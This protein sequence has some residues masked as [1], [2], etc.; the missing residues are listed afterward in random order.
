MTKRRNTLFII[1]FGGAVIVSISLI[2]MYFFSL[3][4]VNREMTFGEAVGVVDIT[5]EIYYDQ[6]KIQE[7]EKYR[8]NDHIKAV[9]IH[10]NS[11]GGGVAASQELY[12]AVIQLRSHKPVVACLGA[13]A[14]S[15]GYYVACAADSIVALE[16]TV[17]GSIGVIA[18]F[19]RT[20]DLYQKIGLGVTVLKSGKYKD[21]GSP[22]R[23]MTQ[24]EKQYIGKL[25]DRVYGQFISAVSN[26]RGIPYEEVEKLAEGRIYSGAEAI[27]VGL[28]DRLGTFED[29]ILL[30][31]RLG[32]ISGKPRI[33]HRKP[34][35][36]I[37]DKLLGKHIGRLPV[38]GQ[39]QRFTLKYIVP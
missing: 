2:M 39:D 20:E 26:G 16:G 34:R 10:I 6:S 25:L 9:V 31:A 35:K 36:T 24:E 5:G 17:T 12:H 4:I 8:E 18:T 1:F 37:L 14:A 19:L 28:V 22:Y 30:A 27:D 3:F 15:G 38:I 21:V 33:M 13:L 29:S 11:P 23:K 32:G 7:I